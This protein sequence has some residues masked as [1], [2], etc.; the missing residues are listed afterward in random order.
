MKNVVSDTSFNMRELIMKTVNTEL[1]EWIYSFCER[2]SFQ[3][4]ILYK[5]SDLLF[6]WHR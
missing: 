5:F 3:L 1:C 4:D 6:F 2:V